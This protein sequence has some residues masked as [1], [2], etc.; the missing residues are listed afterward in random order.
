MKIISVIES[1]DDTYGGPASSLPNLLNAL[2]EIEAV[3]ADIYSV[4]RYEQEENHYID[5]YGLNW[6]QS[7][8][9]GPNKLKI[10]LTLFLKLFRNVKQGDVIYS[11]NLW[12]FCALIPYLISR[13]KRVKHVVAIRGS[14][15]DWSL[16]QGKI[17]KKI[18]WHCFQKKALD[19]ASLI[20][21]TCDDEAIA[22]RKL[23]ITAPLALVSHGIDYCS[24]ST[25]PSVS[26]SQKKLNLSESKRYFLF[27]SRLHEKKGLDILIDVWD[28]I[29]KDHKDWCLL[30]AGPDY[31]DY[32]TRLSHLADKIP[33]QVEYLGMLK[34]EERLSA[35]S[36]SEF[37]VL[38]SY[39]ENFGVAIG[40]ALASGLP[41]IT[42]TGTPWSE[43]NTI[44]CG[45]CIDLSSENF[46]KALNNMLNS[47]EEELAIKSVKARELIKNNYSWDKQAKSFYSALSSL[48]TG[49]DAP[50]VYRK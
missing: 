19:R 43:I 2:C 36:A 1:I 14:L 7:P 46:E 16:S 10:S 32:A 8:Q 20:H 26:I 31:S 12:N 4:Y 9:F 11:N 27:M 50:C 28:K 25:L 48:N 23:G 30:V 47:S 49:V 13:I 18:A 38:P 33:G 37:F 6:I 44:N 22:V 35:L 17:R 41:V 34:G 21:V 40:E 39:T 5:K 45:F 3:E 42:T 15:Y 29:S 24:F